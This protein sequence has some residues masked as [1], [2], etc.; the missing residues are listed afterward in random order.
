MA[1]EDTANTFT[2]CKDFRAEHKDAVG[3]AECKGWEWFKSAYKMHKDKLPTSCVICL[4]LAKRAVRIVEALAAA[5]TAAAQIGLL[6]GK[7][8]PSPSSYR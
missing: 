1:K 7:L 6:Q 8:E 4:C 5:E 2:R 3:T